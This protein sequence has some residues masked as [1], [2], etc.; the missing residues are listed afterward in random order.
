MP[1]QKLP[2]LLQQANPTLPADP[3]LLAKPP[4]PL[5]LSQSRAQKLLKASEQGA[6]EVEA[7]VWIVSR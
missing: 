6:A 5:S 2:R 3:Q 7:E 4:L 1:S